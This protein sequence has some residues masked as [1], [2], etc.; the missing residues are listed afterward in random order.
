MGTDSNIAVID[1]FAG[2]GGLGEGF[3]AY[4]SRG[5]GHPFR[6]AMSVEMNEHAHRTLRLRSFYRQY[7][8]KDTRVPEVYYNLLRGTAA[9][10]DLASG[11]CAASW[12][13]AAEEAMRAELG[14]LDGDTLVDDRIQAEQLDKASRPV[15]LLGGPPCQAYSHSSEEELR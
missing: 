2:P 13:A 3:S 11:R 10:S 14:T 4:R 15:V 8:T 5:S 12:E 6:I 7:A 1:L 9:E